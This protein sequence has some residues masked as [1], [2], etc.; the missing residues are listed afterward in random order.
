MATAHNQ[1][2]ATGDLDNTL[3]VN[4]GGLEAEVDV[5]GV[6]SRDL[7]WIGHIDND[8]YSSIDSLGDPRSCGS[9]PQAANTLCPVEDRNGVSGHYVSLREGRAVAAGGNGESSAFPLAILPNPLYPTLGPPTFTLAPTGIFQFEAATTCDLE[10]GGD[11]S[12]IDTLD[13]TTVDAFFDTSG[14]ASIANGGWDDGGIDGACHTTG[15]N[16]APGPG[17]Y[18]G[19][20]N[21]PGCPAGKYARA[22]DAASGSSVWIGVSCDVTQ[23]DTGNSGSLSVCWANNFNQQRNWAKLAGCFN[24]V[25]GCSL[26]SYL[27]G[28][29]IPAPGPGF[30][31]NAGQLPAIEACIALAL[32]G[33]LGCNVNFS[34]PPTEG[35]LQTCITNIALDLLLCEPPLTT[36]NCIP[37]PVIVCGSDSISD[38]TLFGEGGGHEMGGGSEPLGAYP[39]RLIYDHGVPFRGFSDSSGNP[40]PLNV[41]Q[42]QVYVLDSVHVEIPRIQGFLDGTFSPEDAGAGINLSLAT[43]GWISTVTD[44][45]WQTPCGTSALTGPDGLPSLHGAD[46]DGTVATLFKV[47]A[48]R[49]LSESVVQTAGPVDGSGNFVATTL[50]HQDVGNTHAWATAGSDAEVRTFAYT[51]TATCPSPFVGAPETFTGSYTQWD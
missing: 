14:T 33:E 29:P 27:V 2:P 19:A 49:V 10:I 38:I 6:G 43:T 1:P 5:L 34:F 17:R 39:S 8:R 4:G 9:T 47:G 13:E 45:G 18:A 22:E 35:Q 37:P 16:P 28:Q 32:T 20:D 25:Y 24:D 15:Y 51:F 42:A 12:T 7:P 23:P 31:P 11:G 21:D 30:P 48:N 3:V 26:P 41:G 46:F 36:S 50:Q 44:Q 40:C